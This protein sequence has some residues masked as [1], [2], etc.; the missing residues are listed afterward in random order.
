MAPVAGTGPDYASA[1][2]ADV[3]SKLTLTFAPD[4]WKRMLGNVAA[5]FASR[6]KR[7]EAMK[8]LDKGMLEKLLAIVGDMDGL[9]K[10]DLEKLALGPDGELV[11]PLQPSEP[12]PDLEWFPVTV[13]FGGKKWQHVGVRFKGQSSLSVFHKGQTTK[14][15][16][17]LGFDHYKDDLPSVK[18]QSFFGVKDLMLANNYQDDSGMRDTL[19]YN[20]LR[21]AGLPSLHTA[22]YEV[23]LDTGSGA[24]ILG[25]YTASE[26]VDDTG[27]KNFFGSDDGNLYEGEG[28]GSTLAGANTDVLETHFQKKNN[29]KKADWGD[30]KKLHAVLHDAK[31]TTDPAAWR[32]DFEAVFD[33]DA[34][35]G[36]L[37]I[38]S[39]VGH[40]DS[41]G[42]GPHNF[43]LYN[44]GG[45]MTFISW[46]HNL[47][48]EDTGT[49]KFRTVDHAN[50]S[51]AA[52][53]I[54]FLLDD[55]AY[56]ARY[57]ELLRKNFAGGLAPEAFLR[58][59]HA[60]AGIIRP[61]APDKEAFDASVKAIVDFYE[62]KAK[63]IEA[64][65]AVQK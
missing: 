27:V 52:P 59:V 21:E 20:A 60:R 34:F 33:V 18:G 9:K 4:V 38:A 61:H 3:V 47:T 55:P 41:Y 48:L 5:I 54:R 16:M 8:K 15:P 35:L 49:A 30:I 39:A 37:G 40:W 24:E 7:A 64:Y 10:V 63:E 2:P 29:K 6:A 43:Y 19:V 50:V 17:K 65:L 53:L 26:A 23:F 28:H 46:D 51:A 14:L 62:G 31:R 57:V 12:A 1:F 13:D 22:A 45:R 36:W 44:H 42:I 25:L 58:K 56:H 32:K 11:Q